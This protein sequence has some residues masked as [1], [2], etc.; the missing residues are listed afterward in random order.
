MENYYQILRVKPNAEI[1][2]IQDA[3]DGQYNYW[4]NLVTCTI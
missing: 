3:I 4:R 2:E 1:A